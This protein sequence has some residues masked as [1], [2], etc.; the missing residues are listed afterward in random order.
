MNILVTGGAGFIGSHIVDAL[1]QQGHKVVVVDNLSTGFAR[2]LNPQCRFY[3]M[4]ICDP[5]LSEVFERE[6][7]EVV[8]HQAA[9]MVIQRSVDDPIFDAEQNILGS[10]NLI[11]NCIRS[12]VKKIVYEHQEN[13]IDSKRSYTESGKY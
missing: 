5:K 12:G 13:G 10:L 1:L 2:N 6:K 9:Q 4:S 11:L 7:P 3:E 8:N